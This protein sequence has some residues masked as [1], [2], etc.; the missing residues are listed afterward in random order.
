M[1]EFFEAVERR[2][3]V[4]EFLPDPVP[5]EVLRRCLE[6]ALLAPSSSNL[7]PWEF[8]LIQNPAARKEAERICLEQ[9]PAQ[10]APLLLA[11]V[12]HLDTWRRNRD[13]VLRA[14]ESRGGVRPSLGKYYRTLIP[15]VYRTGPFG[16]L[17]PVKTGISRVLSL[18]RPTPTF[19]GRADLRVLVHK[20][21]ALA[22]QTF[23]LALSAEGFDS[24]PMEGFDPWRARR[25]LGLG[26]GAEVCMFLAVGRRSGKGVWWDRVLMP[27]DW[28]VRTI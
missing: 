23:M 16:I 17:G 13:E 24:C 4:R 10:T 21:T 27:E 11:V 8:V 9:K 5:E 26:R 3:T 2:R 6:A 1:G 15:L 22:A 20:S 19:H 12:A 28:M 18:F 7:Q 14:H 25:L